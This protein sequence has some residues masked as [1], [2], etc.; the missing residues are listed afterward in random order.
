MRVV[1]KSVE[2]CGAFWREIRFLAGSKI[3]RTPTWRHRGLISNLNFKCFGA[4]EGRTDRRQD[5][6]APPSQPLNAVFL[7]PQP[8]ITI[9]HP[10]AASPSRIKTTTMA[11]VGN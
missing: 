2:V 11:V 8:S 10:A 6:G 4:R 1:L 7:P 3:L 5:F 9:I